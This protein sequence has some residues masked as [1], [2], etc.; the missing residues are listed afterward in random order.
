MAPLGPAV[1]AS[2][3]STVPLQLGLTVLSSGLRSTM[4]PP[5][6]A[7]TRQ[8]CSP[9]LSEFL[10]GRAAHQFHITTSSDTVP[11]GLVTVPANADATEQS[12]TTTDGSW[13]NCLLR[14]GP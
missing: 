10:H 5:I 4:D 1:S 13:S 6:Q 8:Q 14:P 2:I 12:Y 7:R 3:R 9:L 11:R